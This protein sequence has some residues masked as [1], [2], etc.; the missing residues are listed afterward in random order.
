[1]H[2]FCSVN[3]PLAIKTELH[4]VPDDTRQYL[5]ISIVFRTTTKFQIFCL[6]RL[7]INGSHTGPK[8]ASA[9][10]VRSSYRSLIYGI[11][12]TA[13]SKIPTLSSSNSSSIALLCIVLNSAVPSDPAN[14]MIDSAPAGC[15]SAKSVK[16]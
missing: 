14:F 8:L 16:S 9:I 7:S 6:P 4:L 3:H 13:Y 15:S 12:S 5:V 1:M 2:F 10:D 11:F